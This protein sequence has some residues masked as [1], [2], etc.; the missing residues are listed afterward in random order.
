MT[1]ASPR[2]PTV[3]A[4]TAAVQ[5]WAKDAPELA[6]LLAK[7]LPPANALARWGMHLLTTGR[8]ADAVVAFR[9][10]VALAPGDAAHWTNL[11]VALDRAGTLAEACACLERSVALLRAQPSAWLLLGMTRR[12]LGDRAG[13]E[14]AY[15]EARVQEPGS[16]AVQQCLGVLREEQRDYAGAIECFTAATKHAEAGAAEWANLAKLHYETGRV[17]E[18]H[19]AYAAAAAKDPRN[20]HYAEMLRKVR[21]MRDL[22]DGQSADEAL[23]RYHAGRPVAVDGPELV[24]LL[25]VA[26]AVL[27][28]SEHVEAATRVAAKRLELHPDSP[29]AS[30]L[31]DALTGGG[32]N[33]RAPAAYVVETFD[34]FADAFDGKLVKILGY[35]VPEKLGALVRTLAVDGHLHDTLDAGCGTGLC[36]PLLRPLSRELVGVDL[37][38]RMLAKAAERGVYDSLVCEDLVGF[39]A[40]SS[41]RFDLMT[42]ADVLIYF[43]D[44]TSL[45]AGAATVLRPGG[46]LAV[47]VELWPGDGWHLH[48]TGRF[49]HS[50]SH[51]RA[52]A[53]A[54][55]TEVAFTETRIRL[56][57][58]EAVRGALLVF[59]RA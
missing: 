42:A 36:G 18:A 47:S 53:K 50:T 29:S 15:L 27:A 39:L 35:D 1:L 44:L 40:R 8:G 30:Y 56:D 25:D 51:V 58:G 22:R 28:G 37:S 41:G 54:A 6:A 21:F 59:R 33:D 19:D 2:I 31:L 16:L 4:A 9:A 26:A 10:A 45:F 11:G 55:F 3:Q 24:A 49:A 52:S 5:A 57:V 46:L 38:P 20:A 43:G 34:A 14:A 23:E 12:K 48:T 32:A 17:P 13:A 7:G